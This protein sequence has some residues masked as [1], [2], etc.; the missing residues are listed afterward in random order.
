MTSIMSSSICSS[1]SSSSLTSSDGTLSSG[2]DESLSSCSG[3]HD[4]DVLR[5]AGEELKKM[6]YQSN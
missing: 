3:D 2:D 6:F 5:N 1:M 4:E